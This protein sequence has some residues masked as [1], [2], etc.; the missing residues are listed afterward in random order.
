V[1]Q[2]PADGGVAPAAD[3]RS[4]GQ[5][6]RGSAC[7]WAVLVAGR[8]DGGC[9]VERPAGI[10]RSG[11]GA[12]LGKAR[13]PAIALVAGPRPPCGVHAAVASSGSGRLVSSASGVQPVR[14]PAVP[15][16]SP[17]TWRPDGR[18]PPVRCPAG[19]C[20][21]RLSGRVR[22]LPSQAVALGTR[23][24]RR[25]TLPTATGRSPGGRPR[26]RV[27]RSRAEQAWT[28]ARL[29][30]PRVGQSASVANP[31]RVGCGR[32]AAALTR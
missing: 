19:W 18:C 24:V 32:A 9:P 16:S 25:G 15:G 6:C 20:P 11:V 22:L 28:R 17:G 23:P 8:P 10:Q 14:C 12:A 5:A 3:G 2:A 29:P 30:R 31:G 27:A 7:C 4:G 21:P 1:R 26:R 13:M